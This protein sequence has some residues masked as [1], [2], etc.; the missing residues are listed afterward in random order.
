MS[1]LWVTKC[2][3]LRRISCYDWQVAN[4]VPSFVGPFRI[5]EL[6]GKNAVKIEPTGRFKVLNPIVNV[7]YLRTYN[8][9]SENVGPPPHHLS[10]KPVAVEPRGEWYRIAEILDHR[11]KAGPAQ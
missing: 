7:E 10:V 1:M 5:L 6:R 2:L 4:L 8:E 9:R 11:G 3:Y